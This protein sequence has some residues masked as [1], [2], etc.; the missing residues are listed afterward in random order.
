MNNSRYN[1]PHGLADAYNYST[2]RD[3]LILIQECLK[4]EHFKNIVKT[5]LYFGYVKIKG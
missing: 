4:N 2:S 3:Q 5:K 1:N